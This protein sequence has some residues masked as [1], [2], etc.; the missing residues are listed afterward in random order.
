MDHSFGGWAVFRLG[1]QVYLP[2][3]T[4]KEAKDAGNAEGAI[5]LVDAISTA[6][7]SWLTK[8]DI[9]GTR[10]ATQL[11]GPEH[12]MQLTPELKQF[13]NETI[14]TLGVEYE[15]RYF[16]G[17]IHAFAT[18]A[19]EKV[20]GEKQAANRAAKAVTGWFLQILKQ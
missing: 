12:D 16:P 11:I 20:P 6:H 5:P 7:P 9:A 19:E 4:V 2:N 13:A 1:A 8:E 18:K 10:V 3:G 15:Y 14:P 17:Q